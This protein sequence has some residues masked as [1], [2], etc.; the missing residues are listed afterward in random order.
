M[1]LAAMRHFAPALRAAVRLLHHSRPGLRFDGASAPWA[2]A[3]PPVPKASR[4]SAW[5]S[6]RASARA[7]PKVAAEEAHQ[8]VGMGRQGQAQVVVA[9]NHQQLTTR[10]RRLQAV[11]V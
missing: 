3:L 8:L 4:A 11:R 9:F 5:A 6:A 7:A 10:Q 2:H 1:C